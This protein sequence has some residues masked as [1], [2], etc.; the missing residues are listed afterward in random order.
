VTFLKFGK[1][2]RFVVSNE[3]L[4]E[5]EITEEIRQLSELVDII[6]GKSNEHCVLDLLSNI[7][8][9]MRSPETRDPR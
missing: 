6:K 9:S 2:I 1:Q 7:K 8:S 4:Q 5:Y 3:T